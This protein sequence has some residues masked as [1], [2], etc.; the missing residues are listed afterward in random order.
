MRLTVNQEKAQAISQVL[1]GK[2]QFQVAKKEKEKAKTARARKKDHSP[3]IMPWPA[4]DAPKKPSRRPGRSK[5]Q[6]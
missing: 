6:Y 5:G 4:Q 1:V 2:G 3:Q